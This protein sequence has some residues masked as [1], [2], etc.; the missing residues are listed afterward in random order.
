VSAKGTRNL[1][2]ER[3]LGHV[4]VYNFTD[5]QMIMT[6]FVVIVV[7]NIIIVAIIIV[8]KAVVI[9]DTC[10]LLLRGVLISP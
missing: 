8:I 7:I 2:H 9:T 10:L 6:V 1:H 4:D 3:P 5:R